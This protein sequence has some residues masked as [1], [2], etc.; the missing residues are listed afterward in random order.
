MLRNPDLTF[1]SIAHTLGFADST[2]FHRAFQRWAELTPAEYRAS[3][4][5]S[6]AGLP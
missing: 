4:S 2:G 6:N 1:Q 3:V 5:A